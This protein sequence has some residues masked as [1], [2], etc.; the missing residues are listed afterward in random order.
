MACDGGAAAGDAG[1][2]GGRAAAQ[3]PQRAG[4]ST[5]LPSWVAPVQNTGRLR[6]DGWRQC[7][8]S[9]NVAQSSSFSKGSCCAGHGLGCGGGLSSALVATC[10][11]LDSAHLVSYDWMHCQHTSPCMLLAESVLTATAAAALRSRRWPS[12]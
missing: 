5:F 6:G 8:V 11:M 10:P 4:T 12:S 2:A 1:G 3:A 9:L 7:N